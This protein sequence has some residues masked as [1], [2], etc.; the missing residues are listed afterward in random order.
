MRLGNRFGLTA[1]GANRSLAIRIVYIPEPG[2]LSVPDL[3]A[4][5]QVMLGDSHK[6]VLAVSIQGNF[7]QSVFSRS[8]DPQI[9]KYGIST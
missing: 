3:E 6:S 8:T 4:N 7:S 9:D 2:L 5:A 1:G